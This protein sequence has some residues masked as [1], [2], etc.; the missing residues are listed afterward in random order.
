MALK[1]IWS[2]QAVETFSEIINYLQNKW[3]EKEIKNFVQKSN[4]IIEHIC[5]NPY[6][7]KVSL[8]KKNLHKAFIFKPVSL[9]YRYKPRKQEIELVTFWINRKKPK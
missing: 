7:Y 6:L 1:V 2:P 3:T 4:S 8:K 5:E 9:V